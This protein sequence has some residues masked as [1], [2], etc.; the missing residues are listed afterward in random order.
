MRVFR[1]RYGILALISLMYFITYIDRTNISVAA[2]II[3]KD[4]NL[5]QVQL[6]LIFSAFAYPYA[7][8]QM[9]GGLFGDLLGARAALALMGLLWSV[10]T[11][12]TGFSRTVPQFLVARFAL[13]LG[14][15]GAFPTATRAFA[16]WMPAGERGLAQGI[17]HSAARLGGALTPPVV[18]GLDLLWGWQSSFWALGLVCLAWVVVFFALFRNDP[19]TDRRVSPEEREEIGVSV[20]GARRRVPWLALMAKMWP[21]TLCD[22]CYGWA[23]WVYLTWLPSYLSQARHYNLQ[24]LALYTAL[25]LLAGVVGDTLGGVISDFVLKRTRNIRRA[26]TLQLAACLVAAAAFVIPA[27]LVA[28]ATLSVVLLSLSFFS[29]ELNNAVLWAIPMDVAPEFAGTAGGMMNTGF[30]VAGIISPVVFGALV[31]STGLWQVPFLATAAL[32]VMGALV[33]LVL[34]RPEQRLDVRSPRE[35]AS[36]PRQPQAQGLIEAPGASQWI[37]GTEELGT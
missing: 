22:F 9:P 15:G 2:P 34:L 26:R 10:A 16:N 37:N 8:L 29:L 3:A 25:P 12:A 7:L 21:V 36:V 19:Q 31:Q 14:E 27:P 11:I 17:P 32:L 30:G 18:I 28:S 33:A 24:A 13:G 23:L 20:H 35:R 1:V 5:N 4:L 6:G